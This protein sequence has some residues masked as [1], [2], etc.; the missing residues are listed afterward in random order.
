[1]SDHLPEE[2]HQPDARNGTVAVVD[3]D[4]ERVMLAF[5]GKPRRRR[6]WRHEKGTIDSHGVGR[7]R[8]RASARL[9]TAHRAEFDLYWLQEQWKIANGEAR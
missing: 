5:L 9:I 2:G 1:M 7:A 3:H 8:G 6:G 4:A